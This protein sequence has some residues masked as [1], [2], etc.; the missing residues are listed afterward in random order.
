MVTASQLKDELARSGIGEIVL[1]EMPVVGSE[2]A[3]ENVNG[4]VIDGENGVIVIERSMDDN[5]GGPTQYLVKF[6]DRG[7][8][9]KLHV[10]GALF[11]EDSFKK[12]FT[13]LM[14]RP[15]REKSHG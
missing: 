8:D 14:K 3:I 12:F 5:D 11:G 13:T 15:V 10:I 9:S 1:E 2:V 7:E 4:F 6:L